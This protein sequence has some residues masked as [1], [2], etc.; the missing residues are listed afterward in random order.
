MRSR[1]RAVEGYTGLVP[2]TVEL[3]PEPLR[4]PTGVGVTACVVLV[5]VAIGGAADVHQ[6]LRGTLAVFLAPEHL[7][8]FVAR[9]VV[10]I[11]ELYLLW[12]YWKGRE[13]ARV[14]VLIAAFAVA[15]FGVSRLIDRDSTLTLLMSHPPDFLRLVLALFLLYWL[16][17]P[18]VR[19]WFKRSSATA[20]DLMRERLLERICTGV[21]KQGDAWRLSFED[22]A[23]LM[24]HCPWRVVLDGNLAFASN[25]APELSGEEDVRRTI[26]NLRVKHAR[27]VKRGSA[28]FI[29]LEMGIELQSWSSGSLAEQWRYSD[30][31]LTVIADGAG[32]RARSMAAAD[33]AGGLQE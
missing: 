2:S 21:Q 30:P 29:L 12:Q 33:G 17:T 28:L 26:Q 10:L 8:A 11:F 31:A 20:F 7:A 14:V 32:T 1:S 15:A 24:L 25:G 27:M 13:W 4:R 22:D 16:N 19:A 18:P 6:A 23:E 9:S 5:L 3:P